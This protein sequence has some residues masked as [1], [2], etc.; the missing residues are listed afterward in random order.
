MSRDRLEIKFL[1][2][3]ELA[4]AVK[5]STIDLDG[6]GLNPSG[7]LHSIDPFFLLGALVKTQ[8]LDYR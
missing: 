8:L 4:Q 7:R 3:S 2:V 6:L 1:L 5:E